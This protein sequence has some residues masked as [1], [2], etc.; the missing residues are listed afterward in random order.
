MRALVDQ[1]AL[2]EDYFDLFLFCSLYSIFLFCSFCSWLRDVICIHG[3]TAELENGRGA[4]L[5][6]CRMFRIR[7]RGSC[8]TGPR[9]QSSYK[10]TFICGFPVLA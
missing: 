3:G 4:C 1:G 6:S 2:E 5:V 10:T 9:L 7:N 8:E